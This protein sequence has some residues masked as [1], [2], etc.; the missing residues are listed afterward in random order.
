MQQLQ[1]QILLE[2]FIKL[3]SKFDAVQSHSTSQKQLCDYFYP[4][5]IKTLASIN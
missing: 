3:F 2:F 4:E 5:L 1:H